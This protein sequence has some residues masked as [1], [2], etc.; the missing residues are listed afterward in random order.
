MNI[1]ALIVTYNPDLN[2][3]TEQVNAVLHQVKEVVIV[4][5]FSENIEQIAANHIKQKIFRLD[6]NFGIGYAQN[7]GLVYCLER[8]VDYVILLDQDSLPSTNL[9]DELLKAI[10]TNKTTIAGPTYRDPRTKKTS[11]FVTERNGIPFRWFPTDNSCR[12][13]CVDAAFLIASGTLIN[14]QEVKKVGGMRSDYFIDHVDTEWC[15][16]LRAKGHSIIGVPSAIMEH[17]LGDEVKRIWFFGWRQVSYHSPL[18]DYYMFRNT[19]L[20]LKDTPMS[21]IW[22]SHFIWR[23]IQFATYFLIFAPL[24]KERFIKMSL[25]IIHGLKNIRGKLDINTNSCR[26]IPMTDLDPTCLK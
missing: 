2:L 17:S 13:K 3:L 8:N 25:G 12:N 7:I 5:N 21:F 9:I 15:F 4:D 20:M 24:R 14:L 16:R 23:L 6:Q 18:R 19:I 11:F 26:P 10:Q 1:S 22:K